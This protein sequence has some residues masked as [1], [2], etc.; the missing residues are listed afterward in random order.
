MGSKKKS[1][2][3]TKYTPI[4]SK[5]PKRSSNPDSYYDLKPSW[6]ISRIELIDPYGWHVL[7][8]D[9]I[10]HVKG[11]LSYFEQM[12]WREILIDSK[13]QNHFI[14]KDRLSLNAQNRLIEIGQDDLDRLV[15]LRLTG[16]QRVWGIWEQ[17]TLNLLWWD[18]EHQVCPST[19]KHT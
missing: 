19:L 15:S 11:K 7:D 4:V 10:N 13:K 17:G 16:K 14:D 9:K 3:S 18:P 1:I 2:P 8:L 5:E 12:T 6:R